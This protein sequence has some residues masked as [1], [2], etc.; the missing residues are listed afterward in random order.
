MQ[1]KISLI[2]LII[3]FLDACQSQTGDNVIYPP[4]VDTSVV[5]INELLNQ[6]A[7]QFPDHFGFGRKAEREKI[8]AWDIDI[9]PDGKG[10]PEG[11]GIV[12]SGQ[13]IYM[14]KCSS[15]HGA[16]GEGGS[17]ARLVEIMNDTIKAKTIGNY[18]PYATTLFDY[19][20]RAMPFNAPGSLSNDEVYD[21]TAWLLFRNRIIDSTTVLTKRNLP[22]LV[23]P[24]KV[25]F[26]NDDRRGG[27]EIK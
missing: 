1:R 14:A 4:G 7:D 27:P 23:M 24:A 15:C 16:K 12:H 22:K 2:L 18:W 26:V 3:F 10:L 20:R 19:I 8:K 9:R 25:L 21:L 17:S 11:K 13:L 5:A 6:N